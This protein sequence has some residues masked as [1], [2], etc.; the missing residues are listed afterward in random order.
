MILHPGANKAFIFVEPL[1][2]EIAPEL[3]EDLVNQLW[4]DTL[5]DAF[6]EEYDWEN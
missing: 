4:A 6:S 5:L 3:F 2:K 1:M